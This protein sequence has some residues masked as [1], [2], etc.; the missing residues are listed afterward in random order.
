M[1]SRRAIK[2][3]NWTA[4]AE[5]I[6]ENERSIYA[7]FKA[8]SDQYLRRVHENP[9][10][11]PK[12]DWAFYKS[13]IGVPGL[14]DKFQKEYESL[15]IEYPAD[16]YS[17]QIDSQEK[18]ALEAVQKFIQES[19]KRIEE[20]KQRITKLEGMLKYNQMTMEDFKDAHPDL[21]YDPLNRP[22]IFPHTPDCQPDEDTDQK[23]ATQH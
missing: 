4:L 11:P 5:R 18:E 19:N 13:R 23:L 1:A 6:S 17:S 8:K 16:K 3:I 20:S 21:A 9:E 22:T 7:A 10:N 2:A 12:I 14:V 15:K